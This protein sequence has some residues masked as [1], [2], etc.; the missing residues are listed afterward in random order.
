[1]TKLN[2]SSLKKQKTDDLARE[3]AIPTPVAQPIVAAPAQKTEPVSKTRI[4]L[5]S[6]KKEPESKKTS[7]TSIPEVVAQAPIATES[8][9][10]VA[11][12]IP[13]TPVASS[14]PE[15]VNPVSTPAPETV[16]SKTV[17]TE[18]TTPLEAPSPK[19]E[20]KTQSKVSKEFFPNLNIADTENFFKDF[21]DAGLESFKKEEIVAE[22]GVAP[23]MM[24]TPEV[25]PEP[26]IEEVIAVDPVVQNEFKAVEIMPESVV[27]STRSH[28]AIQVVEETN[29]IQ[30]TVVSEAIESTE[31]R[32]ANDPAYVEE[33]AK[34]LSAKRLGGLTTLI[35]NK[36]QMRLAA[37][38]GSIVGLSVFGFIFGAQFLGDT[39]VSAPEASQTVIPAPIKH[40]VVTS[41]APQV[42]E[43][44][45]G[46][47]E[48]TGS[49]VTPVSST[50]TI[51]P[52]L[53]ATGTT[54]QT[55]AVNSSNPQPNLTPV[56]QIRT[57]NVRR[58]H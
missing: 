9:V 48:N 47:Q 38:F 6:F 12:V 21:D 28:A 53:T 50:G 13:V 1:M 49:T 5:A 16:A 7:A 57:P 22:E 31:V 37:I 3:A 26:I 54:A 56:D 8:I 32:A 15:T 23:I 4:S 40:T 46:S 29:T 30:A 35:K 55:G 52:V 24:E 51:N 18:E 45:S 10:P 44:A 42:I 25:L 14:V 17:T 19:I 36:K 43:T 2:M 20:L 39:K 34:D 27:D 33:V 41:P 11:P 58:V